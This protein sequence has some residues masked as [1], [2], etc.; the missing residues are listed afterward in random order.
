MKN[1]F[2]L[3][4]LFLFTTESFAQFKLNKEDSVKINQ[5]ISLLN[6]GEVVYYQSKD[7]I[8]EGILN[9]IK[10]EVKDFSLADFDEDFNETDVVNSDLPMR[11]LDFLFFN[12]I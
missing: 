8:P 7:N 6:R 1:G 2:L 5:I 12:F 4:I 9:W 11:K 10:E 3:I